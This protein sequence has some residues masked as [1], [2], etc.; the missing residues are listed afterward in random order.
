MKFFTVLPALFLAFSLSTSIASACG[1]DCAEHCK[2]EG[3]T[4]SEKSC[5]EKHSCGE[6]CEGNSCDATAAAKKP[7][8]DGKACQA[9]HCSKQG[10]GSKSCDCT[11]CKAPTHDK[12]AA[13]D[14]EATTRATAAATGENGYKL[15]IK[16]MHCASCADTVKAAL[17]KLPSVEQDSV[18]IDVEG[19]KAFLITKP[20]VT[21]DI[22]TAVNAT[23]KDSGYEVTD[24]STVQ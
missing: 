15:T 9:A 22:K 2:A 24:V 14:D 3:K 21:A 10:C 7:T 19:N 11:S 5:G 13:N 12:A 17:L 1:K 8:C 4:C 18:R 23:L 20:G 16:G 6:K